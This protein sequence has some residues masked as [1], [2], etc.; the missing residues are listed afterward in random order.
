MCLLTGCISL[1]LWCLL[2]G[3]VK[4]VRPAFLI[5]PGRPME[6]HLRWW[7]FRLQFF[8]WLER[9]S[10]RPGL[11]LC[12]LCQSYCPTISTSVLA[13]LCLFASLPVVSIKLWSRVKHSSPECSLYLVYK[14]LQQASCRQ[15]L[16]PPWMLALSRQQGS[17]C[18]WARRFQ[19][20]LYVGNCP[21]MGFT[22]NLWG[23]CLSRI[24]NCSIVR[25]HAGLHCGL[26]SPC[27][28]AVLLLQHGSNI[29]NIYM[30][31]GL[32]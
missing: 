30:N 15:A 4:P 31:A 10:T 3:L 20:C 13:S 18:I 12:L 26:Y 32:Q 19:V 23:I 17:Q 8:L 16:L 21:S 5:S 29:Q 9:A 2:Y 25:I 6:V 28:N 24:Q 1:G 7:G 11:Q 14:T 27:W 22:E